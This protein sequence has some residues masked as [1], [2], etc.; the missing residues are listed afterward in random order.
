MLDSKNVQIE[1][2]NK[3]NTPNTNRVFGNYSAYVEYEYDN[4][5][6]KGNY[7]QKYHSKNRKITSNRPDVQLPDNSIQTS[8]Y[9]LINFFPK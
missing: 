9:T 7:V 2:I 3:L 4:V 5:N 1:L 8:K 6:L